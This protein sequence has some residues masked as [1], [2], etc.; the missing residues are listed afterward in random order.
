MSLRSRSPWPAL[1]LL[2]GLAV[3]GA[4]CSGSPLTT[5][6]RSL[7][8]ATAPPV[9]QA[10]AGLEGPDNQP[11]AAVDPAV[12]LDYPPPVQMSVYP[13]DPPP[14]APASL[15]LYV[16]GWQI[17]VE[18]LGYQVFNDV[19]GTIDPV[20]VARLQR[21]ANPDLTI[22]A[23]KG[24]GVLQPWALEGLDQQV[25]R[26][27]DALNYWGDL[28]SGGDP[29]WGKR[30]RVLVAINGSLID[31]ITTRENDEVIITQEGLPNQGMVMSG[32]YIDRFQDYQNRSGSVWSMDQRVFFG[33]CVEQPA[34]DQTVQLDMLNPESDVK[35]TG[36]NVARDADRGCS[37][38]PALR[39][40]DGPGAE[41][42][43][44]ER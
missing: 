37:S 5:D 38:I 2:A 13:G 19:P 43:L 1:A 32:W 6:P 15:P 30:N 7:L 44:A 12:P 14:P 23:L 4:A 10:Q 16:D 8:T 3:F 24:G 17:L 28:G 39:P 27:D 41:T 31:T 25:Q 36:I 29:Y 33:G 20:H 18:G 40:D 42:E 26:Y 22:G 34:N 9:L 11:P 35:I 21:R